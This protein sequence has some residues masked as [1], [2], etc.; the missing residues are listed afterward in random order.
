MI[1]L[2]EIS[3]YNSYFKSL[4]TFFIHTKVKYKH[5]NIILYDFTHLT[6][7][8]YC[9]LIYTYINYVSY[10]R[11][12]SIIIF[13]HILFML[14]FIFWHYININIYTTLNKSYI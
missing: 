7:S 1:F 8:F 13:S 3:L 12:N 14:L 11:E 6:H 5:K 10:L 9:I 2:L 4:Y